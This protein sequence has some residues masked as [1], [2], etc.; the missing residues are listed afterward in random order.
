MNNRLQTEKGKQRKN[1]NGDNRA[2]TAMNSNGIDEVDL[3]V[4][5]GAQE[6]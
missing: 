2:Q 5:K 4:N 6:R 3:S 1:A